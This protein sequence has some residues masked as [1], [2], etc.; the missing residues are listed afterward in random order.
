MQSLTKIYWLSEVIL[1]PFCARF[2]AQ[3]KKET[4]NKDYVTLKFIV[5]SFN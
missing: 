5:L 2:R 4:P 1:L 3:V